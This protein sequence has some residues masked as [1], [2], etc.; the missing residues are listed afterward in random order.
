MD[1]EIISDREQLVSL[2]PTWESLPLRSFYQHPQWVLAWWDQFASPHMQ[3]HVIVARN[4]FNDYE[5]DNVV[6]IAPLYYDSQSKALRA[7]GDRTS[8]DPTF[9]VLLVDPCHIPRHSHDGQSTSPLTVSTIV[10]QLVGSIASPGRSTGRA[11][12]LKLSGLDPRSGANAQLLQ[13]LEQN[14]FAIHSSY[15]SHQWETIRCPS[16]SSKQTAPKALAHPSQSTQSQSNPVTT[17]STVDTRSTTFE[18]PIDSVSSKSETSQPRPR[19]QWILEEEDVDEWIN[20]I[21]SPEASWISVNALATDEAQWQFNKSVTKRFASSRHLLS[22]NL[23]HEGKILASHIGFRHCGTWYSYGVFVASS[24]PPQ[25]HDAS[26]LIR[27]VDATLI[28]NMDRFGVDRIV[29]NRAMTPFPLVAS[30]PV[31]YL[32]IDCQIPTLMTTMK[33]WAQDARKNW[34]NW[35]ERRKTL[36]SDKNRS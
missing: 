30:Q 16:I 29:S 34:N 27:C 24:L 22:F 25:F 4:Q 17:E 15:I 9:P 32:A 28:N 11:N 21:S 19:V 12:S 35:R 7:L 6:A 1:I 5:F 18:S 14:H 8:S 20:F 3:L 26:A 31:P 36:K 2:L 23:H 33:L 10:D 13:S